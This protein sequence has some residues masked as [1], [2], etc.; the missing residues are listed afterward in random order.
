MSFLDRR[1]EEHVRSLADK[2]LL[3][4]LIPVQPLPQG[5]I[6]VNGRQYLNLSSNDYLGLSSNTALLRQFYA[7]LADEEQVQRYAPGSG[8]S[9]LLTGSRDLAHQLEESLARCYGKERALLFN[10]GWQLNSGVLPA[11]L[12][13]GDLVLADKLCHASL[14]DGLRLSAAKV[15]RY[16]HL[17]YERLEKLLQ[18]H[19]GQADMIFIVTESI[20]SMDGDCADLL[21]LAWLRDKY[22][23]VLYLDE[24]HAVGVRGRR[25]LGL[26]EEQGLLEQIDLLIGTF[27]KAYSGQG[28]FLVSSQAVA[29]FL[30]NTARSFIFTTALPPVSI[31]W[32]NFI[33]P[34]VAAM[35]AERR[36]LA[37]TAARLRVRLSQHGL[38]TG[39]TSQIVPVLLGESALALATAARLRE[40]GWWVQ[41]VRPPTVPPNSARLR[42]SLNAALS[43]KQLEGLAEQLAAA[44]RQS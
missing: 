10:S 13:K 34:K 41:A 24:A 38:S 17:D 31:A 14:I 33:L 30:I 40:H 5:K 28:A 1:L 37:E 11:L 22:K 39:G 7:D 35:Q 6:A 19:R 8:A 29:D 36:Q 2:G 23:A 4:Q 21:M 26:A 12:R 44:V 32:L 16:A 25:G 20:F 9:R 27:G 43:D 18:Q 42:L 15:I 3:R